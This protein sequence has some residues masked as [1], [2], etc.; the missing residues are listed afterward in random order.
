MSYVLT[1]MTVSRRDAWI[2]SMCEPQ[3]ERVRAAARAEGGDEIV[4]PLSRRLLYCDEDAEPNGQPHWSGHVRA[5]RE[6]H[7]MSS[8]PG[9]LAVSLSPSRSMFRFSRALT[10]RALPAVSLLMLSAC[11][12]PTGEE[13]ARVGSVTEAVKGGNHGG[14][15]L[16]RP[17]LETTHHPE[18][19]QPVERQ[20]RVEH[21]AP[22]FFHLI[23]ISMSPTTPVESES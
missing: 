14:H 3:R 6:S 17:G 18:D 13:E 4:A 10:A 5:K 8:K 23:S 2:R 1:H 15:G 12:A 20:C 9:S 11:G 19:E 21:H 7:T 22:T 16:A